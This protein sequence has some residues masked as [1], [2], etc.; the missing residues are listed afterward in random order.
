MFKFRSVLL[1]LLTMVLVAGCASPG[2]TGA[3]VQ[4]ADLV[5]HNGKVL[6]A[7]ANFRVA[8]AIA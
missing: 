2:S 7:D 1:S 3:F 4:A 8:E 6:T 5:L